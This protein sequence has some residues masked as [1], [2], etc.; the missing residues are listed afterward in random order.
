V[1][2]SV[3]I[4]NSRIKYAIFDGEKLIRSDNDGREAVY[5]VKDCFKQYPD[6]KAIIISSV[7]EQVQPDL[8]PIPE[9]IH[10]VFLDHLTPIPL[11]NAYKSPETLGHDR[12]ALAV[13][14][15]HQFPGQNALV[16]DIG[17]CVTFD[18]VD[19]NGIY[20]GGRISP[21]IGLRF[22]SMHHG[23]ARLPLVE[24]DVNSFPNLLGTDT[25]SCMESGVMQ[26]LSNEIAGTIKQFEMEF[27]DLK[28]MMTGGDYKIFDKALKISIF[29]DPNAVLRGLN[30]I[31][32]YNLPNE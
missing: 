18:L 13:A 19:K 4:G 17:T 27:K 3:D 8:I 25:R 10:H 9:T 31:L 16:I 22:S 15:H 23:T 7:N 32:L 14:A 26:G 12:I 29:A 2:L 1:Q 21:G 30:Q 11:K 28:I 5:V 20:I 24:L 6:I